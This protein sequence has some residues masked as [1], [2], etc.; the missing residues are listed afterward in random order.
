M[1]AY[2]G[3][4]AAFLGEEEWKGTGQWKARCSWSF[5]NGIEYFADAV[6]RMQPALSKIGRP[7]MG[8]FPGSTHY[9]VQIAQGKENLTTQH[10]TRQLE[11]WQEINKKAMKN[12]A[13]P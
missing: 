9:M 10:A 7:L 2:A 3:G 8:A 11:P 12:K 6:C 13:K 4:K 1:L 5:L